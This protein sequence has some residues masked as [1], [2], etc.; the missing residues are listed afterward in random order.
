VVSDHNEQSADENSTGKTKKKRRSFWRRAGYALLVL[1]VIL[2]IA[3]LYAPVAVQRYVNRTLDRNPMYDGKIGDVRLHIWRGA[4]SIENIKL[5]KT[6][7]NV[8]V[9][10]FAA[11]RVELAIEWKAL[12]HGSLVGRVK[13]EQPE[14]NFVDADDESQRQSGNGGPWLDMLRDLF[15][16]KINTCELVDG[17]IRFVAFQKDP[18]VELYMNHLNAN[19]TNFT[20]IYDDTA[21]LIATVNA[22]ATVM[23]QAKLE[24]VMKLDPFSYK[25]TFEMGLKLIGLDVKKTNA[26]T[27]AYGKFD[28]EE[29][30]FDLV[31]EMKSKEGSLEG[32]VKPL[33]RNLVIFNPQKDIP[34]DNI[35]QVFWEALVG[36][37]TGA[38][39]NPPR[40]QFGTMI[41]VRGQLDTPKTDILATLGNVLRN[42]FVRAYL[43]RLRNTA[44]EV[45][46]L[47]FSPGSIVD[48]G[49]PGEK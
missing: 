39:T 28:F 19:L 4:Y 29:G 34:E 10:L 12:F 41:P 21:P 40:Q 6:T 8:P 35:L 18:P 38:L 14:L 11:K 48:A 43:P 44:P 24:Y 26:L 36:V 32:Y 16:F 37:V 13:M 30:W 3:R 23:D 22:T 42:A 45:Q 5:I 17:S 15:P 9:P 7:G 31:V 27:R 25:P 20:N 49:A 47:E 1:A 2:G 46:V 33:F